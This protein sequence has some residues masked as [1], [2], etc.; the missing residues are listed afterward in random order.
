MINEKA[1]FFKQFESTKNNQKQEESK[2]VK[3]QLTK[4]SL[5]Q[6]G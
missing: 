5:E 1:Y 4:F 6:M 2:T 3:E